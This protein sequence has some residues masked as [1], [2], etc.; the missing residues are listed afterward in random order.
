MPTSNSQINDPAGQSVMDAWLE[1]EVDPSTAYNAT[2]GIYNMSSDKVIAELGVMRADFNAALEVMRADMNAA[3]SGLGARIDALE[4]TTA[5]SIDALE[6]TTAASIDALAATT[7]AHH[8]AVDAQMA[9]L[10]WVVIAAFTI[11]TAITAT[12]FFR[13][14]GWW[15]RRAAA[16]GQPTSGSSDA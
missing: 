7:A 13:I 16:S 10:S 8:A 5:A 2:Q 3:V 9:M 6:A 15:P 12:G 14:I 1:A 4:A 11:L